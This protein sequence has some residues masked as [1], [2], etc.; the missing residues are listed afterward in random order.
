MSLSH[1]RNVRGFFSDYYLG[2]VFTPAPARGRKKRVTDW[3]TDLAYLRFRRIRERAEGRAADADSC[4]ERF[5]RP[6]LRDVLGFHLG[7]GENRVHGLFV[8][9]ESEERGDK[10]VVLSYCGS[11]DEDLDAGRGM[12]NPMRRVESALAKTSLRYG[13]L[14]TGERL[15]LVRAPGEGPHGAHL[16]VDLAGLAEDGDSESF[17]AFLR[18]CSLPTFLPDAEGKAPIDEIEKESRAHAEKVSDDLKA[19]VFTAA[20]S[21]IGALIQEAVARGRFDS[22]LELSDADLRLYR[23]A[24][25]TCLYRI[26]F[27]LYAEARDPRLDSHPIYRESYSAQGLLEEILANPEFSWPENRSS[28]WRRLRALFRIYDKGLPRISQWENIPPRGS[29]FFSPET[30]EGQIIEATNLSDRLVARIIIDLATSTPRHG[31]GRERV[32]FRELDIENLGTVYEGLLEYEPR[33]ARKTTLEIRVQGRTFCLSPDDLVRLCEQKNLVLR[34][35]FDIVSGTSAAGLHPESSGDEE[36]AVDKSEEFEPEIPAET[37]DSSDERDANIEEADENAGD[38]EETDEAVAKGATAWLIRKLEPGTFLFVPGP[39]KKGSGS[40]YTPRALV[41]DLVR[42]TLG[43]LVKGKTAAEIERLRILDPACGSAHFLVEAMR[44]LGQALHK[45]YVEEYNGRPPRDFRSTTGQ[46][47]D[48]DWRSSDEQARAANS[49]ARAWCKRRIAERCLFGVDLNPTAVQL[50][51]VALWIESV[52]G[53]RPLTYFEHHIRCGN[54]LLGTWLDRLDAPPVPSL[55]RKNAERTGTRGRPSVRSEPDSRLESLGIRHQLGLFQ[56]FVHDAAAEAARL[57]ALI[58]STAPDDLRREGKEPESIQEQEYK[59]SLRRR[60]EELLET[61]KL[62]FDL[63]SACAFIPEIWAEWDYLCN[64]VKSPEE[65]RRHIKAQEWGPAFDEVRSRER[66]FHWELEYPEVFI[67]QERPGFD[68]VLGN[69]PW[70]KIKPDRKEFY[71]RADILIRAFKGGELDRRVAELQDA[72]PSLASAFKAY[73]ERLKKT[74]FCLKKGGDFMFQD[75][76]IEGKSTGGDP[77]LF[78]FF[79]ERAWKLAARDGRV[80]FVVPSAIYNNEGCTGLRHLLLEEA[81]VERFYAFEN[82]KKI[83][84]IDSRYKFVSL[85]FR[86]TRPEGAGFEAAFMRHDL[87]EL[88]ETALWREAGKEFAFPGPI[89]WM[90]RV[91]KEELERLSPGTLAFLEYRNPRDREI[92][93][94]MYGYDVDGNP[95]NP[96]PLLGDQGPGTWNA[97]FYTE[98]HM[99]NDRDLWT[100][101][102]TGK[103][104]NPRQILGAVP[105]TTERP[106]YYDPAAWPEIRAMMAEKGFWP[107]YEGKHIEQFLIDIKPIERWV[108][109][110]AAE[111]K[112]GRLPDPGPK[113]V[114]RA[115]ARNTDERTC[116]AAVLP[117]NTCFAHSLYGC[118]AD[119]NRDIL[120]SVANSFSFDFTFRFRVS[121]NVSPM[122]LKLPPIPNITGFSASE[123]LPTL[124]SLELECEHITTKESIWPRLWGINRRVAEAYGLTPDDFEY[125]LSTFPVFARKRPEFFAYL[126]RRIA[127]WKEEGSR[128]KPAVKEYP[129]SEG[130]E[131]ATAAETHADYAKENDKIRKVKNRR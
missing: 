101:P 47:W 109:L 100:D 6:L 19:A 87:E 120:I 114:F 53:D 124:S 79:I 78:K 2:S 82:R 76:T 73:E 85:V 51:R 67:A 40:F 55:G 105:G 103:L 83:F 127:E 74:A 84:P 86:K 35:D 80:G 77:D 14:V 21:L 48:T 57:R 95:T 10:P 20:E 42:H 117:K 108:S 129:R 54:S 13:L 81:S 61:V 72:D 22:P 58:D 110:E 38:S 118:I 116:I 93:L 45:T 24:A 97:R 68:V 27:I 60:A 71:G 4:R 122:Y 52:A 115:I 66:F 7:A 123:M 16:E 29:D 15:R 36:I 46:G 30:P 11:W 8:S 43:P 91:G 130:Q 3:D 33:I 28:F 98:F 23:D 5:I 1:L 113:L 126:K 32:S 69:P 89:P 63:R 107:L 31:V 96:R 18:L 26:L 44:F 119:V 70:E 65:L 37:P 128:V 94:K 88:E 106:P 39:A 12:A 59:D 125:I 34:G 112:T 121:A 17:S 102:K 104:W 25:L 56:K 41:R 9:A 62:L 49:E 64:L 50:A 75:W 99:T 111:K 90:V 131:I 92:L